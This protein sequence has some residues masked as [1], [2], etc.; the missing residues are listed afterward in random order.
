MVAFATR[1]RRSIERNEYHGGAV[2]GG[3]TVNKKRLTV[4]QEVACE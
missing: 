3:M 2:Y 1:M 4:N